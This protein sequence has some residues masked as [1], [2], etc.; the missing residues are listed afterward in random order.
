MGFSREAF[1]YGVA[2]VYMIAFASLYVQI[3]GKSI[4]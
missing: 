1:L 3:P 4:D 2:L